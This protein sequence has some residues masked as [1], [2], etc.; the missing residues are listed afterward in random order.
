MLIKKLLKTEL[1][2]SFRGMD[3]LIFA[4]IL[5]L[6]LL[7]ILGIIYGEKPAFERATYSMIDQSFGALITIS[8]CAGGVMGLPI[9]ISDYRSKQILKRF[10]V[11]PINPIT[12]LLVELTVYFIYALIS[13]ITLLLLGNLLFG[14]KIQGNLLKVLFWWS[15]VLV[16][17]FSIGLMVGG[18]QRMQS[19]RE[20]S[21]V[22]S[23]FQCLSFQEQHFLMKSCLIHYKKIVDILPLTQGIKNTKKRCLRFRN[24]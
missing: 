19:V 12:I 17:M 3:M 9:V 16:S 1:K 23:I 21:Q 11:T 20:L 7:V 6:I 5:P 22:H 24:K 13:F 18:L 2:L 14:F 8:I 15:M 10:K 4:V